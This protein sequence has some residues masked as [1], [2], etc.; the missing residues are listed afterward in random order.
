[1]RVLAL[2]RATSQTDV[3]R[4]NAD[5]VQ[6]GVTLAGGRLQVGDPSVRVRVST[7]DPVAVEA[8]ATA[9]SEPISGF[10]LWQVRSIDEAIEWARRYPRP[11]E[12]TIEIEI[13]P[14]IEPGE[15]RPT[16]Q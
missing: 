5:L 10:W 2:V 1:M 14:V 12:G 9:A 7:D 15:G 13:R 4:F 3:G 11:G 6:A 8:P 16:N